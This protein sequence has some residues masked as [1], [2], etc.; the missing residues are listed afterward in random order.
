MQSKSQ[1]NVPIEI[2]FSEVSSSE[3][4]VIIDCRTQEKYNESHL[5][6]AINIP[7]QHLSIRANDLPCNKDDVIYVYCRTGNRSSTFATYLRSI[8]FCKCQS[9]SEGY[10]LWGDPNC[11]A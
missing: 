3:N 11:V 5:D 2:G 10:E 1:S 9:I 7:L 6:G 4:P 8:G